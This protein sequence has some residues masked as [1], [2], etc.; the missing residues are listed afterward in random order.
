MFTFYLNPECGT[1]SF[2][3][4]DAIVHNETLFA[5]CTNGITIQASAFDFP[6]DNTFGYGYLHIDAWKKSGDKEWHQCDFFRSIR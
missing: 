6:E 2:Y 4:N 1:T 3:I 5:S